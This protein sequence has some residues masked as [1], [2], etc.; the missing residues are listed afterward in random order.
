[1]RDLAAF[2]N[3]LVGNGNYRLNETHLALYNGFKEGK[4]GFD[5]VSSD[6]GVE[7]SRQVAVF[8]ASLA[9]T[10]VRTDTT[11][12]VGR[13]SITL[14]LTPAVR[15]AYS[16]V[17]REFVKYL[18]DIR[19]NSSRDAIQEL[20]RRIRLIE[21]QTR[22][23]AVPKPPLYWTCYGYSTLSPMPSWMGPALL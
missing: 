14:F 10:A 19:K 7:I 11:Q 18:L 16:G 8:V 21:V 15:Q 23:L 6:A 2:H 13:N 20:T 9:L 5:G 4:R 22:T 3:D 17:T 12:D 1:M